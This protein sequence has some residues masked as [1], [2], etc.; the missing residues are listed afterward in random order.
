MK[1]TKRSTVNVADNK[2]RV[3][4]IRRNVRRSILISVALCILL[5]G[6]AVL[7]QT[8][9][10]RQLVVAELVSDALNAEKPFAVGIR[11]TIQPDWYLYWKNP[12]DA[13]LR[14]EVQWD[15]PVG[16]KAG[17]LQFPVPSK[18]V[19]GD[20]TAYGYKNEIVLLATI[21][22]AADAKG[23]VKAR[24]DW[25]VCREACLR[26][27]TAVTLDVSKKSSEQRAQASSLLSAFR[28]RLPIAQK[29]SDILVQKPTL[30]H[31]G[32]QWTLNA[33]VVGRMANEV[34][35]F[36]PEVVEGLVM[37]LQRISVRRK[38]LSIGFVR[39]SES[40]LTASVRGLLVTESSAF[41][42][43]IPVQFLSQ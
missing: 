29:E 40:I 31:A 23:P 9:D 25:L 27:G 5:P 8:R 7:A 17:D 22:P 20:I 26:G 4:R 21:T 37:D 28:S 42:V 32:E 16:W 2:F 15:L 36:Y 11:F 38:E 35:D 13:G 18:F 10:G 43:E 1:N 30:S 19:H 34:R 6:A 3:A 33:T 41:E 24:L 14:I 12:G 39:Q